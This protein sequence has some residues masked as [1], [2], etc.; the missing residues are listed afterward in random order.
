MPI[1]PPSGSKLHAETQNMVT[2]KVRG[3]IRANIYDAL[4]WLDLAF[5][6]T[7]ENHV[8]KAK[9]SMLV[10]MQLAPENRFVLRCASRFFLHLNDPD[11][12]RDILI[13]SEGIKTDPWLMAAEISM[14]AIAGKGPK[15]AKSLFRKGLSG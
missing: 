2:S 12:A 11:H 9:R 15:S 10:A 14:S 1:H 7:M 5:Y 8:D 6:Q 3:P 4:A 13:R